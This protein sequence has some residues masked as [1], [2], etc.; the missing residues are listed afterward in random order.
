MAEVKIYRVAYVKGEEEGASVRFSGW[1]QA[2]GQDE[3]EALI[4]ASVPESGTAIIGWEVREVGEDVPTMADIT[5][6]CDDIFDRCKKIRRK[7]ND[8][9]DALPEGWK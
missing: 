7:C 1:V 3:A 8:I 5:E 2:E 6:K 4:S 9:W